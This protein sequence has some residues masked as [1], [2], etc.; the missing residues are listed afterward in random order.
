MSIMLRIRI[1]SIECRSH[2]RAQ[3]RRRLS[4]GKLQTSIALTLLLLDQLAPPPRHRL[5]PLQQL[6]PPHHF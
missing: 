3:A 1:S 2:E 4:N 5:L 6:P